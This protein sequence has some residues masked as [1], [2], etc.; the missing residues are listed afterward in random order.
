MPGKTPIKPNKQ[1]HD[2]LVGVNQQ[3]RA[4]VYVTKIIKQTKTSP[5]ERAIPKIEK[6]Q[7]YQIKLAG[8]WSIKLPLYNNQS[9]LKLTLQDYFLM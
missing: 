3:E 7:P 6:L 8:Q 5:K 4:R 2:I 1:Q 9:S